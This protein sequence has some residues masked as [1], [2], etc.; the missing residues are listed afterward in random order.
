MS[1]ALRETNAET[2]RPGFAL[3]DFLRGGKKPVAGEE[4]PV[5]DYLFPPEIIG[6]AAPL[7][8]GGEQE[9]AWNAAA[10]ACDTER[11]HLVHRGDRGHVWF[12]A[13]RSADLASAPGTWCPF[14]SVL[15]GM[16]D[17]RPAPVIYT[18]FSDDTA[19]IM[20]VTQEN[21]QIFRGTPSVIRAK[22]EKLARDMGDAAIVDLVPD[23]ILKLKPVAWNSLSLLEDRARRLFSVLSVLTALGIAVMAVMVW[24]LSSMSLLAYK[25][26]LSDT[27][28]RSEAAAMQ[29]LQT[30]TGLTASPLR[31]E[32][33]SFADVNDGLIAIG[34]WLK[35]YDITDGVV[36]WRAQIPAGVTADKI[37]VI[38]GQTIESLPNGG[39]IIGNA[40]EARSPKD[41]QQ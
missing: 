41:Q 23:V 24:F 38:G 10:E 16:P 28:A 15:P 6:G 1:E 33:A 26:D 8:K 21:L 37:A 32:L 30:A 7:L 14:A 5:G 17:A 36:R 39:F 34:G 29:L 22:V 31:K 12:L 20:A 19:M 40:N 2:T 11:I 27:K 3:A 35:H 18:H 4:L 25:S 13:V 9:I